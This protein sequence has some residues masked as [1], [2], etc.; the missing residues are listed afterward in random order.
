MAK[1]LAKEHNTCNE[2]NK[3]FSER[4]LSNFKRR[5]NLKTLENTQTHE[6]NGKSKQI[7]Q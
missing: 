5:Y 1:E 3:A 6:M 2:S 4:W 7:K